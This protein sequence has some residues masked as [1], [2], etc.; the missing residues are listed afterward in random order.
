MRH[1]LVTAL[2]G[3]ATPPPAVAPAPVRLPG[4]PSLALDRPPVRLGGEPTWSNAGD[5]IAMRYC[6][7]DRE[8]VALDELGH[9]RRFRTSDGSQLSIAAIGR[10]ADNGRPPVIDCRADGT[11]LAIGQDDVPVLVDAHAAIA[12]P[13]KPFAA[14]T[15]RF[16][17]NGSVVARTEDDETVSWDGA[18][19]SATAPGQRPLD[20]ALLEGGALL[21][22]MYNTGSA[23]TDGVFLTR[24]GKRTKLLGRFD[25]FTQASV[26]PDGAVIAA[27]EMTSFAWDMTA[28]HHGFSKLMLDMSGTHLSDVVATDRWFVSVG[29]AVDVAIVERAHHTQRVLERPCGE[30]THV[31]AIAVSNDD[32]HIALA[33]DPNGVRVLDAATGKLVTEVG[34]RSGGAIVA[35]SGDGSRLATRM[36][37]DVRAWQGTT[38]LADLGDTGD[39]STLWWNADDTLGGTYGAELGTW[40]LPDG[41]W[42]G[43]KQ[44]LAAAVRAATG[45]VIGLVDKA[46]VIERRTIALPETMQTWTAAIAVDR[47]AQHVAIVRGQYS[48][49]PGTALIVVDVAAG[50]A[51]ARAMPVTAV[52][53]ADDGTIV[54][55]G[56]DG[57]VQTLD[58][59]TLAHLA[60]PIGA[61]AASHGLVAAA[62][63]DATIAIIDARGVAG[64]LV[65]RGDPAT[66]LAFTA[67]GRRLASTAPD[68]TLIWTIR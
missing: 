2:V 54:V 12:R 62:A 63:A 45:D 29:A 4:A 16:A 32:A 25:D 26:A 55:G 28:G 8:L 52:A 47:T 1:L 61:L 66:G 49:E 6:P 46:L 50:T 59:R 68:A 44:Q 15:A 10:Q 36:T 40:S 11:A 53:I 30:L 5:L 7:G 56:T 18:T 31:M 13:P 19:E 22:Y 57:T 43:D 65:T 33:C 3:C 60:G 24:N 58:G 41:A 67:D 21:E 39:D 27:D 48:N 37:L 34:P 9:L 35:W 38:L 17:D 23:A 64:T 20:S 42:H 14:L 51:T